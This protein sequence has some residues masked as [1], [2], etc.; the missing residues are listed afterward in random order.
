[1]SVDSAGFL[2]MQVIKDFTEDKGT[3]V[4]CLQQKQ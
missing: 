4:K 3:A 1:M 2:R